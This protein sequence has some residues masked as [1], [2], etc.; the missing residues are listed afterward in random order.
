MYK[1]C[2]PYWSAGKWQQSVV[3]LVAADNDLDECCK[4]HDAHYATRKDAGWLNEGD[5]EFSSCA[6]HEG[7][8]G[9]AMAYAVSA[10]KLFRQSEPSPAGENMTKQLRGSATKANSQQMAPKGVIARKAGAPVSMGTVIR[11]KQPELVRSKNGAQLKGSDFVGTV[12]C[13]GVADFGVGKSALLS[14]AYFVGTFLGNMA[15]SFEK[16]R[17]KRLRIVYVPKVSTATGGQVILTSSHSVSEPVLNPNSGTFLQRAMAQGNATMGPLWMENYIDIDC[18]GDWKLVDPATTADPDDTIHE[19]LQ[20]FTQASIAGQVGYLYAEYEVEF[21][22]TIF[23]PHSTS[24]P[25]YTGPGN[26]VTLTD[27]VAV[28]AVSDDI[29]LS[30]P[31]NSLS[32]ATIPNGTIYRAVFDLAGS[33]AATGTTFSNYLNVAIVNRTNT[34]TTATAVTALS[35]VG[36][37]TFYLLNYGTAL[38]A[39]ATLDAAINAGGTGQVFVRTATTAIGSYNFDVALIRYGNTVLP[40]TQ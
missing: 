30:D 3:G 9:I 25:I 31:S 27:T 4:R 33:T 20:V 10:N 13:N 19:E 1:Y 34:S 26:R 29:L 24:L 5:R 40:T 36:G 6:R 35:M 16:Y 39:Y 11:S 23:Q 22:E 21:S 18:D 2:G 38:I 37:M 15:R 28:N 32:L 14:P 17:W 7:P 8:L 12:E